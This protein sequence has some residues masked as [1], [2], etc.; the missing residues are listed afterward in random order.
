MTRKHFSVAFA[1]VMMLAYSADARIIRPTI[2]G[3]VF[4]D[5][6]ADFNASLGEGI[7]GAT[8]RLFQDNGDGIFNPGQGDTQVGQDVSTL[9]D[10][11]YMFDNLEI[12]KSY[13]VQR[14]SQMAGSL[15]LGNDVSGLI[16][17]TTPTLMID[18]FATPQGVRADTASPIATSSVAV[19][20]TEVLG[21]ERDLYLE[22]NSG[23]GNAKLRVSAYS[24][25]LL[26]YDTTSGVR[27]MSIVTW[28]GPD[29]SSS[30]VPAMGLHDFDLT[31]NG[32][33]DAILVK[34]GVD[35]TGFGDR[36]IFRI[37]EGG[38]DNF[39]EASIDFPI[40]DGT[41]TAFG[42]VSLDDFAGS[43]DPSRIDALQMILGDGNKSIDAQ[44]DYVG[45]VDA[46]ANHDFRVNV[47][48]EP[49]S[50][51]LVIVGIALIATGF[52]RRD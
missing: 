14:P 52:Y 23:F 8:V 12:G 1:A 39:S 26:Q 20:S 46:N 51:L 35:L 10:G 45:V 44:I 18:S 30:K 33:N 34:M 38:S 6:N 29:R 7:S 9:G 19:D 15:N 31:N 4:I 49:N 50:L 24:E 47:V 2:G 21:G 11:S 5:R 43:V 42:F 48:P 27:G 25:D 28:D 17:P 16:S 40:T 41:A 37:F 3:S 22:L 36:A 32:E 13:F